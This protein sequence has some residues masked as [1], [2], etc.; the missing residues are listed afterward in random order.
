LSGLYFYGSGQR[1]STNFGGD[2]RDTGGLTSG[3]LRPDGV[4]VPRTALVGTPLNRVD[5]RLQETF[6]SAGGGR[7]L[8]T[9]RLLDLEPVNL[10]VDVIVDPDAYETVRLLRVGPGP[11]P[12]RR[13][14]VRSG[15]L[16]RNGGS[17]N[18]TTGRSYR[19]SSSTCT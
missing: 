13:R 2:V 8:L 4:I 5:M 3:R 11:R 15:W 10:N 19:L 17:V 12:R 6:P 1:Y 7:S 9:E 18:R 16:S 14:A